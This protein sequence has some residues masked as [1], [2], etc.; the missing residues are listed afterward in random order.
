M[1]ST[2]GAGFMQW[3]IAGTRKLVG[4][5]RRRS[6]N[7]ARE[8]FDDLIQDCLVHWL[9]VRGRLISEPDKPPIAFLARVIR[10]KLTDR[11]RGQI[12]GKRGGG[13]DAVSLDTLIAEGGEGRALDDCRAM[14]ALA[15]DGEVYG[16]DDR[17]VCL[18]VSRVF[19]RLTPAQQRLSLL[20]SEEGLSITE[21]G[22]R[23]NLSRGKLYTEIKRIRKI[24]TAQG[25]ADY[26]KT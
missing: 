23:L 22:A 5:F 10:N 26:F 1:A 3:E 7:L 8:D 25:L 6:R 13:L 21:A 16:V 18:D 2:P 17:H 9:M 20:L 14:F 12:S 15:P 11:V 19:A 24:F 4:E